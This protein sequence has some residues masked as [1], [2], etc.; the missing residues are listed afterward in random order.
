[1]ANSIA[2][3]GAGATGKIPFTYFDKIAVFPTPESPIIITIEIKYYLD[4]KNI[5]FL[6]FYIDDHILCWFHFP[7]ALLLSLG[8]PLFS[9]IF[10]LF[11]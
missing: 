7:F 2:I 5:I 4:L 9:K 11:I 6:Y 3:V 10:N 1:M 8:C